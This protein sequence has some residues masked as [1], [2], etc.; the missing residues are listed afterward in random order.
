MPTDRDTIVHD[1]LTALP[2]PRAPRSLLPRVMAAVAQPRRP[3]YERAWMTWPV[4]WQAASLMAVAGAAWTLVASWPALAAAGD[5]ASAAA[6]SSAA[7]AVRLMDA[8]VAALSTV[9]VLH[10]ALAP[11][12]AVAAALVL[13][14]SATC[15]LAGAALARM[16]LGGASRS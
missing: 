3:W 10:R 14:M 16:A 1:A 8:A 15:A 5:V 12:L 11:A 9:A 4:G 2:A 6:V 13:T 7:P